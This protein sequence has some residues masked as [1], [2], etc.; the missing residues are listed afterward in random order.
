MKQS[1]LLSYLLKNVAVAV[2]H[3]DTK[4]IKS[5]NTFTAAVKNGFIALIDLLF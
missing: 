1:I 4:G 2:G 3:L 5:L